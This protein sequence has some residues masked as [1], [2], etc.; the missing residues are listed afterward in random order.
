MNKQI[1]KYLWIGLISAL[2]TVIAEMLQGYVMPLDTT[3]RMTKL[4]TSFELLPIWRIGLGSTL[5][6]IGILGQFAGV[7]AIYLSF[8]NKEDKIAK[9]YYL[10]MYVYSLLGA[11]IHIFM[12]MMIYVYKVN[13]NMN[14]FIDFSVWFVLPITIL[15]FA[16]YI[17]F[18][19]TMAKQFYSNHTLFPRWFWLLNPLFGKGIFNAL[20]TILPPSALSNGIGF[21]NMGISAVLLFSLL[22][23]QINEK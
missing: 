10:G 18:G 15:F 19:Y 21:S 17:P 11:M 5:G 6:A 3:N 16:G 22:L 23:I 12:S 2:I 8:D 7:Y 20:A 14:M 9:V 1:R 13:P 4:F